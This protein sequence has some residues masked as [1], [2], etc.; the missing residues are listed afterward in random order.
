M[1]KD[2][3]TT[4][5]CGI[6]VFLSI[7]AAWAGAATST[8]ETAK[9]AIEKPV[10]FNESAV[11]DFYRGKAIQIVVGHG[12]GGGFDIYTRTIGRHLGKH[13]PGKPSII[14]VNMLGAGG[15]VAASHIYNRA[16]KD[17]TVIGNVI[18]GI[19]RSQLLGLQ[20][21]EFDASK[22]QYVGA[23]NNE[24][25]LLLM[26]KAS[27]I[28]RYEQLLEP[29]GKVLSIGDS[30][31]ATTNHT[32]ALLTRDVLNANIKVVS[33]YTAA[34]GVDVAMDQGE[35]GGQYNDWASIKTRTLAKIESG[36]WLL[37][38]Q[39]TDKP[40]L[41]LPQ[42]NVPLILNYAKTQEQRD[43]LR[44]GIIVPNQFT[45]PYFLPPGVHADRVAALRDAF[46]KTLADSEFLAE[47]EKAKLDI[48]PSSAGELQKLIIDYLAM[49]GDLKRKLVKVLP[50]T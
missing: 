35:L 32:A 40:L 9:S 1:K 13:I 36:E 30:G 3:M 8:P 11:A 2:L 31:A 38:G 21:V 28:S 25:S 16:P 7:L 19:V 33:G 12:A 5:L 15:L 10:A 48:N 26:T 39:L 23:P 17:G 43:L 34:G 41:N 22:F 44:A 20:G 18:G 29:S 47:A 6:I 42:Q 37:I 4:R 50:K 14:V 24:N 46:T 27:G 49:P 45:R